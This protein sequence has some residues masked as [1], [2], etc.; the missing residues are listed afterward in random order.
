MTW[1]SRV[2]TN[3]PELYPSPGNSLT[4]DRPARNIESRSRRPTLATPYARRTTLLILL[5]L[6]SVAVAACGSGSKGESPSV[7]SAVETTYDVTY[8]DGTTVIDQA[9]VDASFLSV[10]DDGGEFRFRSSQAVRDLQPGQVV[11]FAGHALARVISVGEEGGE[12]VVRTEPATLDEAISDGEISWRYP[13]KWQ[14]LPPETFEAAAVALAEAAVGVPVTDRMDASLALAHPG[15]APGF[16]LAQDGP[17]LHWSG[18]VKGFKVEVG[19]VPAADRLNFDL[20]ATRSL[21]L[22]TSMSATAVGWITDFSQETFL[23][24]EDST[25]TSFSSKAIGLEG[26]L[27]LKWAAAKLGEALTEI[28]SFKLPVSLPIP[29][30]V[31]PIPVIIKVGANLQVVPELS[32]EEAS[33]GGSYKVKFNTD[34]GIE[35]TGSSQTPF[36]DVKSTEIGVSGE[37]V[38]AGFGVVGFALGV[39]FPRLE[40][41]VFGTTSAFITLKTYSSSQWTPGTTLTGDIPPCQKGTTSLAAYAGYELSLLGFK[42]DEAV[43]ELW[44]R[45]YEKFLNDRPCTLTGE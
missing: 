31:G 36:S 41:S 10:S 5:L 11:I 22:G 4:A 24:Y 3:G 37:T 29:F 12:L 13:V 2:A 43:K 33:S 21:P 19:F 9:E 39:E 45:E 14:D 27:E 44:K 42:L 20:K 6:I 16:T 32:V 34:Q 7:P 1:S 26:E 30:T 40:I 25:P 28:T 8:T 15:A 18:E 38:S 35:I 23:S 17:G